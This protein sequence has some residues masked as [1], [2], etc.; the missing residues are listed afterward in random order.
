M[1]ILRYFDAGTL[2]GSTVVSM[3]EH[4]IMG[5]HRGGMSDSPEFLFLFLFFSKRL[6]LKASPSLCALWGHRMRHSFQAGCLVK[7]QQ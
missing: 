7:E 2:G 4:V 5:M 6:L 1:C 3:V